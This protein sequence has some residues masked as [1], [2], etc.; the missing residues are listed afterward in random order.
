VALKGR[1][2][3]AGDAY[4]DGGNIKALV[5]KVSAWG[6]SISFFGLSEKINVGVG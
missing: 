4:A 1:V 5:R 3:V 2:W 6:I